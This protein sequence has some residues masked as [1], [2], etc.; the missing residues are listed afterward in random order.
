M[1]EKQSTRL[2]VEALTS[3]LDNVDTHVLKALELRNRGR[4]SHVELKRRLSFNHYLAWLVFRNRHDDTPRQG[5]LTLV[6]RPH[7][8]AHANVAAA[9]FE[10]APNN[11]AH[12]FFVAPLTTRTEHLYIIFILVRSVARVEFCQ[13]ERKR[14]GNKHLSVIIN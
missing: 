2:T 6:R 5:H 13:A 8:N 1:K 11:F 3:C 14:R 7:A 4:E 12:S 10:G 9:A